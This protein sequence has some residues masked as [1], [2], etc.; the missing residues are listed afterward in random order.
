MSQ[1]HRTYDF[2]DQAWQLACELFDT[3]DPTGEQF[4]EAY[5]HLYEQAIDHAMDY[6]DQ[7]GRENEL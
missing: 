5:Q 2:E 1:P 3:D 7:D 6:Y 4:M